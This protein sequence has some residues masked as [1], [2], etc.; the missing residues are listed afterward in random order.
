VR[1]HYGGVRYLN[2]CAG[3]EDYGGP[4]NI[5]RSFSDLR[6][7]ARGDESGGAGGAFSRALTVV[8]VLFPD[9]VFHEFVLLTGV[10]LERRPSV[11]RPP[12][13]HTRLV[14]WW[15]SPLSNPFVP[16][17]YGSALCSASVT[18]APSMPEVV[19]GARRGRGQDGSGLHIEGHHL[20]LPGPRR[21]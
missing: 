8:R 7:I 12:R 1:Q 5:R 17:Q 15:W 19:L 21:P 13:Q 6:A 14:T 18:I 3:R 9:E 4:W 11:W 10:R 2:A 20:R 16:T